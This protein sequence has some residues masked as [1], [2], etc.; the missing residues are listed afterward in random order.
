M[1]LH[2]GMR[3]GIP[4]FYSEWFV[5]RLKEGYVMD[6]IAFAVEVVDIKYLTPPVGG[7]LHCFYSGINICSNK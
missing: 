3:T 5:N 4:A 6:A 1:I 2:T 7:V